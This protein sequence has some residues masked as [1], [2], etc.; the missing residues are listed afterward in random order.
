MKRTTVTRIIS[1]MLTAGM[2]LGAVISVAAEEDETTRL[3]KALRAE[4]LGRRVSAAHILGENKEVRAVKPLI[5]MLE[6][7]I[8]YSA[9]ISAAVA[10]AQIGDKEALS[11]LK[12]SARN[13]RDGNVR[14]VA[15]GAIFEIERTD[16]KIAME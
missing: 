2:I 15:R 11:A 4:N 9:R 5:R 10:L 1:A 8:K 16:I 7:D 12:N 13:D 6:N 3:I 14:T